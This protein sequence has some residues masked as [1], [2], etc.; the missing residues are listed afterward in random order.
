MLG[1]PISVG[2]LTGLPICIGTGG[3]GGV[4]VIG[5]KG[6]QGQW[7]EIGGIEAGGV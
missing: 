6:R 3:A 4:A 5:G 2:E 1:N 7:I